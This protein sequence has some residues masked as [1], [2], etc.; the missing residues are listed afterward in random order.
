MKRLK[1]L[2][3]EEEEGEGEGVN[4]DLLMKEKMIE[5]HEG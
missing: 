3:E 2:E 4:D 5:M 1:T